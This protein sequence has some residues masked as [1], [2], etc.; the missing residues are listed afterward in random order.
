MLVAYTQWQTISDE[1]EFNIVTKQQT[2]VILRELLQNFQAY[3]SR[4]CKHGYKISHPFTLNRSYCENSAD[5]DFGE[6]DLCKFFS[7]IQVV[8]L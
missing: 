3:L 4:F 5:T 7:K 2:A 1:N 8:L 6:K